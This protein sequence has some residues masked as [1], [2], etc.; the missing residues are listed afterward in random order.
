MSSSNDPV[1][2]NESTTTTFSRVI[3]GQKRRNGPFSN[4][5]KLKKNAKTMNIT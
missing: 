3:T 4:E 1:I 2:V 5:P